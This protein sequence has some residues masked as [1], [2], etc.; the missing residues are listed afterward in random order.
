MNNSNRG[1]TSI[2][3]DFPEISKTLRNKRRVQEGTPDTLVTSWLIVAYAIFS[4]LSSHSSIK[5]MALA[6][7]LVMALA[8]AMAM[9]LA[10]ALVMELEMD[11]F[12]F[13]KEKII[14]QKEDK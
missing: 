12:N 1:H 6:L 9:A 2:R 5:A 10:M 7:A 4:I 8:L 11:N 13:Y 3:L 14:L